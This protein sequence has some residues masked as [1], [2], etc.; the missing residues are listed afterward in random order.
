MI[1]VRPIEAMGPGDVEALWALTQAIGWTHTRDDWGTV[2]R[3]GHVFGQRAGAEIAS[4][5]ALF[6][7]GP[8]LASIGM[9]LVA[10]SYRGRG[11]ARAMM[12]HCLAAA[13]ATP[14]MLIATAMGE[15][16]YRTLG[17]VEVERMCRVLLVVD[18]QAHRLPPITA[19]EVEPVARLDAEIFGAD[20]RALLEAL[21]A[22]A[23]R[24]AVVRDVQNGVRGF[25]IAI[26]Q[27]NRVAIGPVV[28]RVPDDALAILRSLASGQEGEVRF[29]MPRHQASALEALGGRRIDD[30]PVMLYGAAAMPGRRDGLYALASRGFG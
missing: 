3:V 1:P 8:S 24:S 23:D 20:R 14:V 10:P 29:E 16:L 2:V 13:G 6:G 18:G 11:L 30:A 25:G 22:R 4:S 9:I 7:F 27:G 26:R 5:G 17:F 15:P 19:D 12:R 21:L 28:A